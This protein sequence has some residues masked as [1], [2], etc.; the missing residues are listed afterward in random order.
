MLIHYLDAPPTL[1]ERL[2]HRLSSSPDRQIR[3]KVLAKVA[4]MGSVVQ[5]SSSL[6]DQKVEFVGKWVDDGKVDPLTPD[7]EELAG[8]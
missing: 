1:T 5:E 7:L 2:V 4:A 8:T 6:V 3:E